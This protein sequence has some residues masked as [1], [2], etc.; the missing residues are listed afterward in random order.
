MLSILSLNSLCGK[1]VYQKSKEAPVIF[2]SNHI[3]ITKSNRT[4]KGVTNLD[5][6]KF[7]YAEFVYQ[8]SFIITKWVA[9]KA[10]SNK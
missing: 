1:A 8:E 4:N 10:V 9:G 3:G 6:T 2:H 5:T 7:V